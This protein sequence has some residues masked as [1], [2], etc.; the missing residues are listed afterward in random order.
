M[1]G[2]AKSNRGRRFLIFSVFIMSRDWK[3]M[4]EQISGRINMMMKNNLRLRQIIAAT[5]IKWKFAKERTKK[6]ENS[7]IRTKIITNELIDKLNSNCWD[8][9]TETSLWLK[10]G[11]VF[12]RIDFR[13]T[14]LMHDLKPIICTYKQTAPSAMGRNEFGERK[15]Q[16]RET[17]TENWFFCRTL[18]SF[19]VCSVIRN[20][21]NDFRFV[22]FFSSFFGN[23]PHYECV[24][25]LWTI[26]YTLDLLHYFLFSTFFDPHFPFRSISL[27]IRL[28]S[29]SH[30][31]FPTQNEYCVKNNNRTRDKMQ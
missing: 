14:G 23:W 10:A 12:G 1:C 24:P 18:A 3:T 25:N 7:I 19:I 4:A 29:R 30:Y 17:S 21:E 28:L 26:N 5:D 16:R 8:I 11:S 22:F 27:S 31:P 15:K 2:T 13:I 6:K 9:H 20:D